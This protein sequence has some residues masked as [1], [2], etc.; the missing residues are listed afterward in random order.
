MK[1]SFNS[2]VRKCAA[3]V[4]ACA[5]LLLSSSSVLAVS[6]RIY[7]FTTQTE[8]EAGTNSFAGYLRSLG[9]TVTVEPD[10]GVD[11]YEFLDVVGSTN[12]A[13]QGQLISQLTNNYDL[14]IIHR[15]YGSGTLASSDTERAIW[16]NLNVPILCCNAPYTRSD[17][18]K[19]VNTASSG[20]L[21]TFNKDLILLDPNHPIVAGLN[22]DLFITNNAAPG[23]GGFFGST[24]GGP[25]AT[26]I[27]Q[28]DTNPQF[29]A[30]CLAVWDEGGG[31]R[32][33]YDGSGQTYIRRRVFFELPD[34]RN[35][36]SWAEISWNGNLMV[37]HAVAYAMTGTVPPEISIGNF[38]PADG[39]QYN[40]TATI[41]SFQASCSQTI[42]TTGIHVTVNGQ[43]VSGSLVF[44]GTPTSRTASYAG[45]V[46]NEVYNISISVS[47]SVAANQASLQFDTFNGSVV[48]ALFPDF[49][50]S[51]SA[52]LSSNAWRI[53]I[54][55]QSSTPQV[56]SLTQSNAS[57]LPPAA[58]LRGVFYLPGS[59]TTAQLFPLTDAMGTQM[60]V[61]T[62]NDT[63]TFIPGTMSGVTVSTLY[64]VPV[65]SPPAAIVPTLGRAAPYPSQIG[66]SPLAN[67]DLDLIDGDT[68]VV[69]AGL[70]FFVDNA[71][72]TSAAQ[73]T[74]TDTTSGVSV[75]Y[76]PPSF[77]APSQGHSVKVI[78]S[79]NAA[80]S[81]TNEY[82]F[83]T[84]QMPAFPP[85]AAVPLST[86]VSN[87][88]NI[89]VSS[90]PNNPDLV[91]TN[92]STRAELQ[93]AGL[94]IGPSGPVT[95]QIS[96]TT[97]PSPYLEANVINYSYDGNPT[98]VFLNDVFYPFGNSVTPDN[99]AFA[100]TTYLQLPAGVVTFGVASA[101]GFK[102]TG[103]Y[104]PN[105]L[106]GSY[107]GPR[108]NQVPS[109]FQVLVYQ[110]GVYPVRLLHYAAGG[111][112]VEFY[113]ANNANASSTS[114]RVLVNG[115]ND[116]STVVV[117][118]YSVA[119]P[120]LSF[121]RQGGQLIV[122]WNGAGNFQLK[123]KGD[124]G[125]GSW[126]PVGQT[127]VVQGWL[128]TVSLSLPSSG[129]MYYRLEMQP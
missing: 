120:N 114:G 116:L 30:C 84:V 91:F 48:Q 33:F 43:D 16:N 10:P 129:N 80:H 59:M 98:G 66:V 73:T 86:I 109:E 54:Q 61:R 41:F 110:L 8:V 46:P 11:L 117:P 99:M 52:T 105:L 29:N 32:G 47:N 22:T 104:D 12:Q 42:P 31:V 128:H 93:L 1:A 65:A 113:T 88:F 100:A 26:L 6:G 77:L 97:N 18:W 34:F 15:S 70:Q 78:Y 62:P 25:Y 89:L 125:P 58:R 85:S 56:L 72:L 90:A 79:D 94:L 108:G 49:D 71:N 20:A 111:A 68:A 115:V 13:L 87:G 121:Q 69:L 67:L 126:S 95:N 17:R 19:W 76:A 55:L 40:T 38:S 92:T 53:F 119:R 63:V 4:S 123:Q 60:I 39:S 64:L 7:M 37:K 74:I 83:N 44:G 101:A 51:F 57:E 103:G 3:L 112:S 107:E 23:Y 102:L 124:L 127:P 35:G 81:F 122:S 5:I 9:Y 96:G 36:G 24:D 14:I 118:A 28:A 21:P 45:L 75:H 2:P 82:T 27:A 50:N 106:L